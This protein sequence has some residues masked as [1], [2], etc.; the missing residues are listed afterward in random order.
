[1]FC[2]PANRLGGQSAE[3][4]RPPAKLGK[5]W[6]LKW[7]D[8]FNGPNGSSP[9]P[10][11]WTMVTGGNGWGNDELE[12]Y[13]P[14]R[15]NVRVEDG[16]LVI[17]AVKGEFSGPD[18]VKRRYTS[19]R[20]STRE[21]FSQAYGRFEARIKIPPGQGVWPAFWLLGDDYSTAGWPDCG[22]IDVMEN[23]D[24][25]KSIIRG[26][27]HGPGYSGRKS[28]TSKFTLSDGQFSDD[29]NIFAIEWEPQAIRF[30]VDNALYATKTPSDLPSGAR[31]V[32]DH[33]FFIILNLAV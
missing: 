6:V 24:V 25:D 1:M 15:E 28:L 9:D 10:A 22:E 2:C 16:H 4:P 8:E 30:Y 23:V 26:S 17:E 13:T 27:I 7:S 20:L 29:F 33:P 19:G 31:W 3:P 18:G 5:N 12:Y 14:R 21:L 11:K 32:Y